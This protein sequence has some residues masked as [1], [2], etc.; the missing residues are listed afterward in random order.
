LDELIGSLMTYEI[1]M[2][3][4]EQGEKPKKKLA[5]KVVHHVKEHNDDDDDDD[6]EIEEDFALITKQFLDFIWKKQGNR[7]FSNFKKDGNKNL[8]RKYLDDT[9]AT[10]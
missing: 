6:D 4:Q 8:A 1:T 5:F 7:R 9:N 3:R 2:K 10:K